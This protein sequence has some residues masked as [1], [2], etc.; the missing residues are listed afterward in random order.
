MLSIVVITKNEEK[1]IT[2]CLESVKWADE[3]IIFDNGSTDRTLE[4]AKKYTANI[5]SYE[6]QDYAELRNLAFSKTKGDWVLYID[7]DE[8]VLTTLKEEILEVMKSSRYAAYAIRRTNIIL[9]EEVHYGP[10][11]DDLMI[12]MVRKDAFK[13]WEGKIHE[14]LNFEGQLGYFGQSVLHLTHRNMDQIVLKSLYW[15]NFDAALRIEAHH[16]Q[17]SSWRFLRI[18]GTELFQQGIARKGFFNGTVGTIDALLQTFSMVMSYIRLWEL[19][20]GKTLED[21]YDEIDKQ[22]VKNEFDFE[23]LKQ[24]SRS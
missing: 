4:I 20:Q 2:A 21:K 10:Y 5:F 11:K 14:H 18:L 17:M 7:A 16:P 12:R 23:K 9:G 22:L 1:M 13:S 6:G 19:Q 24:I 8:R 3:L 15:S